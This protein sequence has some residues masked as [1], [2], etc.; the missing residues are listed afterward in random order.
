MSKSA[1]ASPA[2]TGLLANRYKL[3]NFIGRGGMGEVFLADDVLLGGIP[4]LLSF[5][6]KLFQ[7]QIWNRILRVKLVFVLL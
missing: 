4:L 3:K 6:L 1:F 2:N 5:C 7:I